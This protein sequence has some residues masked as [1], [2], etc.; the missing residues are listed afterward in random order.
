ML[1]CN[2]VV[3]EGDDRRAVV[4]MIDPTKTMAPTGNP[5]LLELAESVKAKLTRA[6]AKVE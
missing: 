2:V 3:Y 5:K 1:P 4:L 6:L